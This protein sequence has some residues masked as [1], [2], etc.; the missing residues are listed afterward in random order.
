MK[1]LT[2]AVEGFRLW[3]A[4]IPQFRKVFMRDSF[5]SLLINP[6]IQ[7]LKSHLEFA[8]LKQGKK[9]DPLT[10]EEPGKIFHEYPG[11]EMNG[12]LTTYNACDTTALFLMALDKYVELANDSS[13]V[14]EHKESIGAAAGYIL[15]HLWEGLFYEDPALCNAERFALDCTYWKDGQFVGRKEASYP[16][17]YSLVHIQNM[18]GLFCAA[19]LLGM[20]AWREK[21]EEMRRNIARLVDKDGF[22]LIYD[23]KGGVSANNSDNLHALFYLEPGDIDAAVIKSI[24]DSSRRLASVCGYRTL[25]PSF[26][27]KLQKKSYDYFRTVWPFEQAMIYMGAEKHGLKEV[28]QVASRV[29]GFLESEPEFL[30]V[31]GNSAS[32]GGCNPQLWTWAAKEFFRGK[33]K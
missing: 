12:L 21:A 26:N 3:N 22:F 9:Q 17:C 13:F 2:V 31:E 4:G 1:E 27:F 30:L 7:F 10:G 15:S 33:I 11:F 5:I 18:R 28:T 25:D 8:I 16:V 29:V 14:Q 6:D 23:T 32:P 24:S 19:R 20:D